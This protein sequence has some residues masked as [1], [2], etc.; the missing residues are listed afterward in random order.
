MTEKIAMTGLKHDL[1]GR[2]AGLRLIDETRYA[3]VLSVYVCLSNNC[4]VLHL[5]SVLFAA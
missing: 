2:P 5:V 4:T 1:R 3:H